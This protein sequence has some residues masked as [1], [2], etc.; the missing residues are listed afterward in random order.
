MNIVFFSFSF[1]EKVE[2]KADADS[3][4]GEFFKV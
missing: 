3:Q 4:G 1:S 2:V